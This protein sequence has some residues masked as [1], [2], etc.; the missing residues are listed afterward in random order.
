MAHLWV[1]DQPCRVRD[2]RAVL[3]QQR[4]VVQVVVP[5]ERADRDP[6]ARVTDVAQRVQSAQVHQHSRTREAKPHQRDERVTAREQLRVVAFA[7]QRDGVLE[8][9]RDLVVEW[10]GDHRLASS[11]ACQTR[12][13]VAGISRSVIP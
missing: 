10:C 12:S 2:E 4:V 7:E 5:G 13:G 6:L 3:L 8:G 11:I 1:A 9:M